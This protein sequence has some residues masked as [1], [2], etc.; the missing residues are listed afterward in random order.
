MT[1]ICFADG[2]VML[3]VRTTGAFKFV[4]SFFILTT[5]EH[6]CCSRYDQ[7]TQQKT[8]WKPPQTTPSFSSSLYI[9]LF[10]SFFQQFAQ[11]HL[12]KK[13][14]MCC[15]TESSAKAKWAIRC[16]KFM[17]FSFFYPMNHKKKINVQPIGAVFTLL[18]RFKD[19]IRSTYLLRFE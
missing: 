15:R 11:N 5:T 13:E 7:S 3:A 10:F 19:W 9:Q 6:C 14:V 2:S 16:F 4:I 17:L 1:N 12:S 8:I 18:F